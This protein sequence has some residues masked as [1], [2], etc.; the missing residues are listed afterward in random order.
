MNVVNIKI[1]IISCIYYY[2]LLLVI[3]NIK[4][5]Q[6]KEVGVVEDENTEVKVQGKS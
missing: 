5:K 2:L 6:T 4:I 1:I 3:L